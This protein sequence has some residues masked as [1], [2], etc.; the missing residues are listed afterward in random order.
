MSFPWLQPDFIRDMYIAICKDTGEPIQKEGAEWLL[1]VVKKSPFG[2]IQM[3]N[4]RM[5]HQTA[6]QFAKKLEDTDV[7]VIDLQENSMK[8][9]G[10]VSLLKYS[11]RHP[12]L[13]KLCVGCNDI[14]QEGVLQLSDALASSKLE[15]IELG[16]PSGRYFPRGNTK[17]THANKAGQQGAIALF[18]SLV[19]NINMKYLGLS[20]NQLVDPSRQD[21]ETMLFNLFGQM[22][23]QN[24]TLMGVDLSENNISNA[25]ATS[26]FR[27]LSQNYTLQILELNGNNIT[28]Q[29]IPLLSAILTQETCPLTI[30]GL[31]NN[32]IGVAGAKSL[33]FGLC[34]NYSL[35]SLSLEDCGLCDE[36]VGIICDILSRPLM[37]ENFDQSV[38]LV[39]G[40]DEHFDQS[41]KVF[42]LMQKVQKDCS[43]TA[44]DKEIL[45]V[46]SKGNVMHKVELNKIKSDKSS[47]KLQQDLVNSMASALGQSQQGQTVQQFAS[48][49]SLDGVDFSQIDT[50]NFGSNNFTVK[51]LKYVC[52]LLSSQVPIRTLN[53]RNN[54]INF[55]GCFMLAQSLINNQYDLRRV[56][57]D[58]GAKHELPENAVL[59]SQLQTLNLQAT[60]VNDD[61]FLVLCFAISQL[62]VSQVNFSNNF[63]GEKG[64]E[65]ALRYI[66]RS[67][68]LTQFQLQNNQVG[69]SLIAQIN[70]MLEKNK[71]R[72]LQ[73]GPQRIQ[74]DIQSLKQQTKP[75]PQYME[76]LQFRQNSNNRCRTLIQKVQTETDD[77]TSQFT[78]QIGNV[79]ASIEQVQSA[80]E[81][82]ESKV[83]EAVVVTT[84]LNARLAEQKGVC[85]KNIEEDQRKTQ[86][87]EAQAK[88]KEEEFQ[89]LKG[90]KADVVEEKKKSIAQMQQQTQKVYENI[91]LAYKTIEMLKMKYADVVNKVQKSSSVS[92]LAFGMDYEVVIGVLARQQQVASGAV[93]IP[94]P[95]GYDI[96][97]AAAAGKEAEKTAKK[98]KKK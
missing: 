33:A 81:R 46:D 59:P 83:K 87:L 65:L 12:Q 93:Q 98:P 77:I 71:E 54:R 11:E 73:N 34:Q 78:K 42:Q 14:C 75:L 74:N 91:K 5:G 66:M 16:N 76:E 95:S 60:G 40:K 64:G 44:C 94:P 22:L 20:N 48:Q 26:L 19:S 36:G 25:G 97:K 47:T 53:I 55:E 45:V 32:Q 61:G 82:G 30:L 37:K 29:S 92:T 86:D 89:Q 21:Q 9:I 70:I 35:Q 28:N 58:P 15:I 23:T 43:P 49:R 3:R 13:K 7:P 69:H 63:I 39:T 50:L 80:L 67:K 24:Q 17:S 4:V 96:E 90:N 51:A 6:I 57:E 18:K 88:K 41:E 10:F 85:Q 84:E 79:Q 68:S 2:Q 52:K 56:L 62:N 27:G 38:K 72:I 1:N 31:N 8:D